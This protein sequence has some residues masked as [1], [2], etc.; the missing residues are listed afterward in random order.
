MPNIIENIARGAKDSL[1]GGSSSARAQA[2]DLR[3]EELIKQLATGGLA[4]GGGAGALVALVNYMK[5]LKEE[6]EINDESR[7]NDDTLYIPAMEKTAAE[8]EEEGGGVNRWL[9]PGLA[10]TGGIL[11]AG[12]AYALTQAVYNYMQKKKR[13]A[14]LDEAQGEALAAADMET[15][16]AAAEGTNINFSDLITAFPVAIPLLAAMASG[17]VAYTALKKTFPT[18][19]SPKSKYP[20]RIRQVSQSGEVSD[21]EDEDEVL[22]SASITNLRADSDC[23]DAALEFLAMV[24]DQMS[25]EKK[26]EFTLTSDLINSVAKNGLN[27]TT[28]TYLDAG[29]EGLVEVVKGASDKPADTPNKMLAAAALC[30]SARMRP[31]LSTLAAAEFQ[32]M[33]PAVYDMATEQ[34][35]EHM[36]KMAGV[37]S[38]MHLSFFRPQILSKSAATNEALLDE[39]RELIDVPGGGEMPELEEDQMVTDL[40]GGDVNAIPSDE[41]AAELMEN[42]LTSDVGGALAED[43]AEGESE[44]AEQAGIEDGDMN[45]SPS[46]P[47]DAFMALE[48]DS[49]LEENER[50]A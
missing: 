30:K 34:G 12:G 44:E 16:K 18:V 7:L 42:I 43:A 35:D 9:A 38:L 22:K 37:A 20:K 27:A 46:D 29:L 5:S 4:L 14:M 24:T 40:E 2:Q 39:L 33:A 6:N 25:I 3:G 50:Q 15:E 19:T 17:G 41:S 8:G 31:I 45:E 23:E 13:Q 48:G 1:S 47:V 32:E 10:M 11:S 26:A 36:D 28:E 21:Y 49:E